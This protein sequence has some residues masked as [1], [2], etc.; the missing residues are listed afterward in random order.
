M[1]RHV[2]AALSIL[3]VGA[4]V[5]WKLA[6]HPETSARLSEISLSQHSERSHAGP[7]DALARVRIRISAGDSGAASKAT[8]AQVP[9]IALAAE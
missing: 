2:I 9:Q 5:G 6:G 4:G 1:K 3:A 8:A 7:T